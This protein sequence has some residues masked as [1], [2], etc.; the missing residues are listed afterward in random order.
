MACM[1]MDERD[2]SHFRGFFL[3]SFFLLTEIFNYSLSQ[4]VD[5]SPEL[6]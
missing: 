6:R 4:L 5:I 1:L 2:I 3:P